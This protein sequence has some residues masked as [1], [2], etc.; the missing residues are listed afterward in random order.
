M[1]RTIGRAPRS[2]GK[3]TRRFAPPI[4]LAAAA[5]PR[6][7]ACRGGKAL[8]DLFARA[9]DRATTRAA[10]RVA[11]RRSANNPGII[12]NDVGCASAA[13]GRLQRAVLHRW[14]AYARRRASGPSKTTTGTRAP[15]SGGPALDARRRAESGGGGRVGGSARSARSTAARGT[16]RR[17]AATTGAARPPRATT[18]P[19][20]VRARRIHLG[21]RAGLGAAPLLGDAATA[22][23][24]RSSVVA[25]RRSRNACH[26]TAE[27]EARRPK[28][29]RSSTS[30]RC[31]G[32]SSLSPKAEI[33]SAQRREARGERRRRRRSASSATSGGLS[34]GFRSKGCAPIST[35]SPRSCTSRRCCVWRALQL[36]APTTITRRNSAPGAGISI[37]DA[38]RDDG[39]RAA[40]C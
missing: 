7:A 1:G 35:A 30:T 38:A 22:P 25:R 21:A 29:L 19:P 5:T 9:L 18:R 10:L 17:S 28:A 20:A 16:G 40:V 11:A 3:T 37:A 26:S 4:A 12:V 34:V 32:E 2:T 6:R 8:A 13:Q 33:T 14:R 31:G 24:W 39:A 23:S 15:R 36:R 27:L